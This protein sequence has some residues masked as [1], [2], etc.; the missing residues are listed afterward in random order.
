[1]SNTTKRTKHTMH[2]ASK[3]YAAHPKC[4]AVG[5]AKHNGGSYICPC[6]CRM[7]SGTGR[8]FRKVKIIS[9]RLIRRTIT[10]IIIIEETND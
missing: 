2:R 10:N 6:C 7:G 3:E 9:R 1:M 8:N 5:R 4:V